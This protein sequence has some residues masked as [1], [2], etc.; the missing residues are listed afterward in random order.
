MHLQGSGVQDGDQVVVRYAKERLRQKEK[1]KLPQKPQ[2][3]SKQVDTEKQRRKQQRDANSVKLFMVDQLWVWVLDRSKC[4]TKFPSFR[5]EI[6]FRDIR[7][8]HYL[9]PI[10]CGLMEG[11]ES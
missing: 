8:H 11:P 9:L 10:E 1:Q 3:Q 2:E 4:Y 5:E 6:D 7:Y